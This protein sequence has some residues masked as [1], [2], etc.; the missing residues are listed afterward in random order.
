[1]SVCVGCV[2]QDSESSWLRR[3]WLQLS[4]KGYRQEPQAVAGGSRANQQVD[5][6]SYPLAGFLESQIQGPAIM[7]RVPHLGNPEP[8]T[9]L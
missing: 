3:R 5:L 1:M 9:S 4:Q 6:K 7:G 2:T 8:V